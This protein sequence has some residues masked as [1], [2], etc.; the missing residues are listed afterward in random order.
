MT[1]LDDGKRVDSTLP[2][3]TL[4]VTHPSAP[5]GTIG[6]FTSL[7]ARE[8]ASGPKALRAERNLHLALRYA[9]GGNVE[10]TTYNGYCV[11][12]QNAETLNIRELPLHWMGLPTSY[13]RC[14]N[15]RFGAGPFP[16]DVPE[17][18]PVAVGPARDLMR[19]LPNASSRPPAVNR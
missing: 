17:L 12:V 19:R 2:A 11:V 10:R 15:F 16:H 6:G 13:T 7:W 8:V 1:N 3:M 18:R 9:A 14:K 4:L 5:D